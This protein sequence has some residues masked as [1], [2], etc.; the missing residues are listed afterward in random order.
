MVRVPSFP[1]QVLKMLVA[2]WAV[3]LG[4]L[5]IWGAHEGSTRQQT[6]KNLSAKAPGNIE[7]AIVSKARRGLRTSSRLLL[8]CI[9]LS[10]FAQPPARLSPS[11]VEAAYLYNFGKFIRYPAL[12]G[13]DSTSFSICIL[14]EDGFGGALDSLVANESIEGRKIVV[15]RPASA[16]AANNCQIVF[17]APSEEPRL[18]RDLAALE[19]KPVLTVSTLPG[20]LE[21]GG[22]IEFVLQSNRV[23]FAVNLAPAEQSGLALS[24]ELLKVAVRVDT[25][26]ALEAK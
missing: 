20:F 15:R 9:T 18:A 22:M 13:Q 10:C 24:S 7:I 5:P 2:F 19:K 17:I 23:R 8:A 14:G 25:K 3:P 21:H 1:H 11:D 4:G 6:L 26:P 16:A 12:Q